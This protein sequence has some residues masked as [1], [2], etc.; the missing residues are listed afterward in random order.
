MTKIVF[1]VLLSVTMVLC[2]VVEGFA[3]NT[4]SYTVSCTIPAIPGVNAPMIEEEMTIQPETKAQQPAGDQD[5]DM[6]V[7]QPQEIQEEE[8]K[9]VL[10][11]GVTSKRMVKTI[12]SR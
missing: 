1:L 3:G 4:Y 11:E 7:Q 10:A 6:E 2:A 12:Y 9:I 8:N 5:S